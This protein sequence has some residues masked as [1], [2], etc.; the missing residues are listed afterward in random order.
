ME[1]LDTKLKEIGPSLGTYVLVVQLDLLER[2]NIGRLG[3][4]NFEAGYHL[5]VGSALGPGGLGGRIRRHLRPD[6]E[7]R[8]HWHIDALTSRGSVTEI[9]WFVGPERQECDWV[10]ILAKVGD[11][12]HRGFGA[13]DCRCAGHLVSLPDSNGKEAAWDTLRGHLG[14]K[15]QRVQRRG[16][17]ELIHD[18][19]LGGAR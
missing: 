2:I 19:I 6:S 11:R 12:I 14:S 7:K 16:V 15:I 9:W 8:S 3:I 13:S 4:L 10:D 17:V 5:Y 18:Q 1:K